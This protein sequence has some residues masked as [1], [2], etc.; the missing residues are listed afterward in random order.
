MET[1]SVQFSNFITHTGHNDVPNFDMKY[2]LRSYSDHQRQNWLGSKSIVVCENEEHLRQF[3]EDAIAKKNL[4]KKMYLGIISKGL[5]KRIQNDIKRIYHDIEIDLEGYNCALPADRIR[6]FFDGHGDENTEKLRGQMAVTTEDILM[7]PKII[8]NYDFI[9]FNPNDT[10]RGN[11]V[12]RF[13]K[14][15][16]GPKTS[17]PY[18]CMQ[19]KNKNGSLATAVNT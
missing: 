13:V 3:V 12:I 7:I 9:K 6:H 17:L 18:R 14:K 1:D 4:G 16:S 8:Q 2:R 15:D 19:V 10:Y 5:A 11:V